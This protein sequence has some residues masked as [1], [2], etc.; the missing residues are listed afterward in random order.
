M[1][2]RKDKSFKK[3]SFMQGA[4]IATFG[5][6]LCKIIGIVYVIPFYAIIGEQGG[7]LYG[8]A[9]NIYSIFLGIS[10]AGIPLAMSKLISE[11]HTMGY[12]KTKERAFRLGKKV[13][14]VMGIISFI[15]LMIFARPLATMI[16]GNTLG[17]NTIEDVEFVIRIISLSVLVVPIMSVYRGYFQGHKIITPTSV[18][19]VLEQ[20]IRVFIII[21][22]SFLGMKV[23]NLSLRNTVGIA[24]FSATIGAICSY[25][26][27]KFVVKKN[28][29][30]FLETEQKVKESKITNKEIVLKLLG[31]AF[32]FIMIDIFRSLY[33]SIDI[34]MLIN[35]LVNNLGYTKQAAESIMSVISTWGLKINQIIISISTGIMISLIPNLTSSIVK[36]DLVDVRKKINQSL[37]II[38]YLTIPMAIGLSIL[39]TNV[40][41]VF[42]GVSEYGPKVYALYVFVSVATVLFTS[43]I[44][45][46][47]ILKDYKMT[48]I[49]LIIGFLVKLSLNV[50]LLYG[51]HKMGLPAYYGSIMA[52]IIGFL[53]CTTMC[54][55]F[56]HK[57]Y[58]VDYEETLKRFINILGAVIVMTIVLLTLKVIFPIVSTSKLINIIIIVIYALLGGIIYLGITIKNKT[59]QKIFGDEIISKIKRKL[60]KKGRA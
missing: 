30:V 19:Q 11:Y 14:N 26:Y 53:T 21:I 5:I 1:K 39:S 15:L 4:F 7:A 12:I 60:I 57:K 40:W 48:F 20:L 52:T 45:T 51:F 8:Y 31:Y 3:N 55:I 2:N 16:I 17:G 36:E 41:N 6:I 28:K 34:F 10:T 59:L 9:Y 46:T 24:V 23:F 32:P 35:T 27:L 18:S 54:L 49:A 43:S 47:Q 37:Q 42:Y 29:K 13:L 58:K 56:L 44:T 38:L 33:N 25:L 22:G 50:P